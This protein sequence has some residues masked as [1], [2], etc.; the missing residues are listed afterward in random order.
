M[1][2]LRDPLQLELTPYE[3]LGVGQAA[4]QAEVNRAFMREAANP[5]SDKKRISEAR[6]TLLSSPARRELIDVLL[7]DQAVASR[8]LPDL[9]GLSVALQP[10][11]RGATWRTWTRL[12]GQN[13]PEMGLVHS[14][15]VLAYWWA[16]YEGERHV[17]LTE[18]LAKAGAPAGRKTMKKSL[19]KAI[20]SCDGGIA[21]CTVSN[22]PWNQD[23]AIATPNLSVLWRSVICCWSSLLASPA[24]W[25]AR[26]LS[27]DLIRE[28][29]SSLENDIKARIASQ[30]DRFAAAG[31]N[32]LAAVCD[33]ATSQLFNEL[34]AARD[35]AKLQTPLFARDGRGFGCGRLLLQQVGQLESTI[36][37][38]DGLGGSSAVRNLRS[39][40]SPLGGAA[41]LVEREHWADALRE[42]DRLDGGEQQSPEA[43][44]LRA[45]ALLGQGRAVAASDSPQAA[46]EAYRQAYA[47]ADGSQRRAVHKAVVELCLGRAAAWEKSGRLDDA[48]AI[49]EQGLAIVRPDQDM[50][51]RLGGLLRASAIKT[52]NEVQDRVKERGGGP[53]PADIQE[54]EDAYQNLQRAVELGDAQAKSQLD[55]G[56]SVRDGLRNWELTQLTNRSVATANAI[57]ERI[58]QRGMRVEDAD[59]Q[60]LEAAVADLERATNAGHAHAGEQLP[61]IRE[62]LDMLRR[63]GQKAPGGAPAPGAGAGLAPPPIFRAALRN[64]NTA[65]GRDDWNAAVNHMRE[66]MEHAP[67]DQHDHCRRQLAT[68][69]TNRAVDKVNALAGGGA[70]G[71]DRMAEALLALTSARTDLVEADQLDPHNAHIQGQMNQVNQLLQGMGVQDPQPAARS[72]AINKLASKSGS[73]SGRTVFAYLCTIASVIMAWMC[74][75]SD[76]DFGLWVSAALTGFVGVWAAAGGYRRHQRHSGKALVLVPIAVALSCLPQY[77]AMGWAGVVLYLMRF[78]LALVTGLL[79]IRF[80]FW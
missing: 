64:A 22:C 14:L 76:T 33:A 72:Q 61:P 54:V 19:L 18:A 21:T 5:R 71:M 39:L 27:T 67:A 78:G 65:A 42:L 59:I 34:E 28:V 48:T 17:L 29:V 57:Q 77:L 50:E 32:S 7:Y 63:L 73:G 43:Q 44:A 8:L 11:A 49:L 68:C 47:A 20:Q 15:G 4:S 75:N 51:T 40:L 10:A 31:A 26:G 45:R 66:A 1:R 74:A 6:Q 55:T 35:M 12:L 60:E 24:F 9:D 38:L 56:R 30:R 70:I 16:L 37:R 79:L 13:F 52:F 23:C 69:L 2:I 25:T 3:V 53:T 46:L 58:Q 62:L 41:V 80:L 36:Q